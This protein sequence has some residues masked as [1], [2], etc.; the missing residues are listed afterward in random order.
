MI[1]KTSTYEQIIQRLQKGSSF[2][3]IGAFHGQGLRR[4]VVDGAPSEHLHA[5]DI[6]SHWDVGYERYRDRDWFPTHSVEA[7]ILLPN[8]EL[9]EISGKVD[10]THILHQWAWEN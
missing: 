6:V 5:V 10:I 7:D 2:L 3:D 4:L 1:P 8:T 9:R